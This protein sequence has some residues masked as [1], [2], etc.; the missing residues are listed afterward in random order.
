LSECGGRPYLRIR[1]PSLNKKKTR[2]KNSI[3]AKTRSDKEE[4]LQEDLVAV[5]EPPV[6]EKKEFSLPPKGTYVEIR[7]LP[8][9]KWHGK[10]GREDMSTPKGMEVLYDPSTGRYATGL[11][12]EERVFLEKK[13]GVD[14]SDRFIQ[15]APHP[16]WSSRAA[17]IKMNREP[18]ILD[19]SLPMNYLK[20]K[21]MKASSLI[22]NSLQDWKKGLYPN[23]TH[24][25]HDEQE[26]LALEASK[27]QLRN[28]ARQKVYT[29]PLEEKTYLVRLLSEKSARGRSQDYI[30]V[31]L[32]K[33]V[34]EKPA[35][36]MRYI[37]MDKA[38]L[39][40]RAK[41]LECIDRNILTKQG[42]SVYYMGDRIGMDLEEAVKFFLDPQNQ[43]IKVVIFEKLEAL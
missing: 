37:N 36:F 3:M 30:D 18:M 34:E 31:E 1:P 17:I 24:Y 4:I 6:E 42:I 40:V 27:V 38:E 15:D 7:P 39:G 16:F 43:M 32:D 29:M 12:E 22:A 23:A 13:L 9:K 2:L 8:L 26:T 14:L 11:A 41:I 5:M 21:N 35:E 33:I 25:I 19:I 20:V 28:K 10:E